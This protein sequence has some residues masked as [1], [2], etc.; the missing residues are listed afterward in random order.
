VTVTVRRGKKVVRTIRTRGRAARR[1]HR[2][3]IAGSRLRGRGVYTVTI[4]ARSGTR[5][6]TAKLTTQR[7]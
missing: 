2:L 5:R 6:A 1:T 4:T 3:R 7:L